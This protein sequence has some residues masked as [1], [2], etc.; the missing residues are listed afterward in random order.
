MK[1][2][3][4]SVILLFA[5]NLFLRAQFAPFSFVQ[6]TD[7]HI[8]PGND[9]ALDDLRNSVREINL[10][11]SIAFVIVSGDV[12]DAGEIGSMLRAKRVLDSIRVPVYVTSGNHETKWSESGC[13][14][15]SRVFGSDRFLFEYNQCL[16]F[17]F[18]TGP[19]LKMADGHVAPQ[20]IRWMKSLLSQYAAG[21][22]VFPVTHY[23]LQNGDVDNW[24]EVTD[25][26]RNY[27]VQAVLGGHYHRNLVFGC[28]GIADVLV[29]SNLRGKDEKGGYTI[30]SVRED[31]IR[32]QEKRIDGPAVQWLSLPF[33]QHS[34]P[35]KDMSIRP[36]FSVN[37]QY[38]KVKEKW[39]TGLGGE[40]LA[41]PVVYSGGVYV[42]DDTGIFYCLNVMNGKIIWKREVGG[43][44]ISTAAVADDRVVFGSTNGN[45]YCLD[46]NKGNVCW[47]F[48]TE[49]AVMGCPVID[50]GIVY[51]GGS[52]GCMRAIRLD[53]GTEVWKFSE[54]QGYIETRPCI[55][56][57]KIFFGAWDRH[58]YALNLA[59]GSLAWKWNNGHHSDKFSPAACWPVA[60]GG[61]LFFTAPDR[62][63]TCLD[64]ETGDVVWRTKE[65]VV[66]E[67]VGISEDG[68]RI[69]SRCMWNNVVAMDATAAEPITLWNVDAE[70][71]Y[72][73][74][75]SMLIEKDGV[76]VFGTKNGLLFGIDALTG[77]IMWKHKI[78]NS[79]IN[80]VFMTSGR[81]VF[82]TSAN[83]TVTRLSIKK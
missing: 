18:S 81:D 22:Y 21:K 29:R 35:E 62:V 47:Q 65:H 10:N 54:V 68:K 58:M 8:A 4:L 48:Q 67:T 74:N 30:I 3:I 1:N 5:G 73:H 43:R 79:V 61:K 49:K 2:T 20:D 53:N 69:F 52:D 31:S 76:V 72:D 57:G 25:I 55:Y 66:R 82:V 59:D 80:T 64:A 26:L 17:G 40:I 15:F 50:N 77:N 75:P 78:G 28:D 24:Y 37:E 46:A 9:N 27:N 14:D 12:T 36:D 51:I 6:L 56:D 19:I 83:G 34:F 71:G 41:A 42:G 32:W 39:Q 44:I 13:T 16:F 63:F 11:D 33:G 7:I 38:A 60:S 23:P 70:Y 45:I